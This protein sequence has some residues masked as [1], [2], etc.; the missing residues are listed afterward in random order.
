MRS[1]SD[2]GA[3]YMTPMTTAVASKVVEGENHNLNDQLLGRGPGLQTLGI[4]AFG[5]LLTS[6]EVVLAFTL[7]LAECIGLLGVTSKALLWIHQV[8]KQTQ[9]LDTTSRERQQ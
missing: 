8:R 3:E 2:S 1:P 9:A 7:Q 6:N 4:T 5:Q